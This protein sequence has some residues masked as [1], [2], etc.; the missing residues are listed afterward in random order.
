MVTNAGVV[1]PLP[2]QFKEKTI[3][4]ID[5]AAREREAKEAAFKKLTLLEQ[6]MQTIQQERRDAKEKKREERRKAAA[7]KR[8]ARRKKNEKQMKLDADQK[9]ALEEYVKGGR[10]HPDTVFGLRKEIKILQEDEK[11][12]DSQT[13]WCGN[14]ALKNGCVSKVVLS[15]VLHFVPLIGVVCKLCRW[16]GLVQCQLQ[17]EAERQAVMKLTH[18]MPLSLLVHPSS[19]NDWTVFTLCGWY[20]YILVDN[21]G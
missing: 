11:F 18:C 9:A 6:E 3:E 4:K 16:C 13:L 15:F 20:L 12:L 19:L 14:K 17:Y 8:E 10:S 21:R 5:H 1:C 7:K 2:H